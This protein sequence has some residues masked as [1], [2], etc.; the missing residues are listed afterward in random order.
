[1]AL[2]SRNL[3]NSEATNGRILKAKLKSS[4]KLCQVFYGLL[5][6][7]DENESSGP[8]REKDPSYHRRFSVERTRW[9]HSG[10]RGG[11]Q[12][13]QTLPKAD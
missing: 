5:L 7:R 4:A 8:A 1:M 11:S 6:L 3:P 12:I 13:Y 9:L 10:I 2:S